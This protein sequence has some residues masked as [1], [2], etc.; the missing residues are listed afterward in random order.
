MTNDGCTQS[1]S[2]CDLFPCSLREAMPRCHFRQDISEWRDRTGFYRGSV[3]SRD[4]PA[5][6]PH[7]STGAPPYALGSLRRLHP[8][9]P[10]T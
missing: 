7:P 2:H 8:V 6:L 10:A 4:E 3:T 9:H 5:F 1:T